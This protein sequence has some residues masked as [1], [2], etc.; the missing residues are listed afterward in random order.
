MT[1][2]GK[3]PIFQLCSES[4]PLSVAEVIEVDGELAPDKLDLRAQDNDSKERRKDLLRLVRSG[5]Q[6]DVL[7]TARVYTQR[8]GTQN[9]NG[10]RFRPG[11]MRRFARS[12]EGAP[13]LRDHKQRD[14]LAVGGVIVESK[15]VE[16]AD[17]SR[18]IRQLIRLSAPWAV[19]L[20]LTGLI[21]KFSIG[22]DPTGPIMCTACNADWSECR[23]R[24]LQEVEDDNGKLHIVEAEFTEAVGIESS[25]VPIPGVEETSADDVRAALCTLANKRGTPQK[26]SPVMSLLAKLAK[27]LGVDVDADEATVLA[28]ATR[29]IVERTELKVKLDAELAAHAAT[30]EALAAAN[31]KVEEVEKHKL[32]AEITSLL[33]QAVKDGKIKP[34]LNE[35]GERV[36]SV[37]EAAIEEMGAKLGLEA[38]REYVAGL[39]RITP[40][41]NDPAVKLDDDGNVP[42]RRVG[43]QLNQDQLA[44]LRLAGHSEADIRKYNPELFGES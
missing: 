34:Q 35:S 23:H 9:R 40:A 21:N 3:A 11:M 17:G 41:G 24:P 26:E 14:S 33:T 16:E 42:D 37:L 13:F 28:S 5:E 7:M 1:S 18:W 10:V 2:K 31:A 4:S 20:A 30:K 25:V 44:V 38:A 29:V 43:M 15:M 6:V 32:S 12:F 19:E 8:D 22:W 39:P 27:S 36:K